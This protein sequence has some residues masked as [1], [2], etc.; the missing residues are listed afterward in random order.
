MRLVRLMVPLL[1]L[2]ACGGGGK[3]APVKPKETAV[4]PPPAAPETE[5]DR[6]K[7]RHAAA[8]AIVP[9][10]S[11]CLPTALKDEGAPELQLAA[12]GTDA[13]VCAVDRD[14]SRLLGLV[15]C[16]KVDLASGAL[17]P[18]EP[19]VPMPGNSLEVKLDDH[20]A[21]GYC[22][23]KDAK[24][25]GST[26]HM[27][28]NLDATKVAVQVGDDVHIFDAGTKAHES[29]FSIRGDKGLT[30]D[31]IGIH[32]VGDT[33]FVEGADQGPYSAVWA[34]KQDGTAQGPIN[35]LGGKDEKPVSTYH[36]SFSVLDK[37]HVGLS[38]KGMETLT[39]YEIDTGKRTKLVR[40]VAKVAC[41]PDELDAFW[42]DGDKVTDKCKD[43]VMKASGHLMGATA[44]KGSTSLL[45][46]LHGDRLGELG[47]L[48]AK[49]LA[50]KKVIK[51]PWCG[52]DGAG[53]PAADAKGGAKADVKQDKADGDAKK[54]EKKPAPTKAAAP[55][56][57]SDPE[58][59]G[60]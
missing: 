52:A 29:S 58:E 42:H 3:K 21:R 10:G 47:V 17:A 16:W 11:K 24:S 9:E 39:V 18:E 60:Q 36:G 43:S 55:K 38:E 20:C 53:A 41:K 45:V 15:G 4:K 51:M 46:L 6:E 48:D 12:V 31:P 27:S 25:T 28:W 40:K 1:A 22:L 59:G 50:E 5:A 2:A 34:F 32:Y 23:P 56:K 35:G 49:T 13:V 7:K 14:K 26:A 57:S 30:N 37:T 33:I 54:D 44:V 19:P 8:I